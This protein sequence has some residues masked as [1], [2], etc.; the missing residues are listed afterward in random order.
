MAALS[1]RAVPETGPESVM[2]RACARGALTQPNLILKEREDVC[3][4]VCEGPII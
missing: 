2:S 4:C 3:V 1:T